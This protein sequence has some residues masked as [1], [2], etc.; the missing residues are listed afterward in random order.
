MLAVQFDITFPG[1]PC[2]WISLDAMDISGD[3]HLDVVRTH[4]VHRTACICAD[5]VLSITADSGPL[6][7]LG[8]TNEGGTLN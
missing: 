7:R 3:M 6:C 5:E 2:E 8:Q 4:P 1:L